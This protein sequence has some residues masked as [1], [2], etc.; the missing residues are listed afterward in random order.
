MCLPVEIHKLMPPDFVP[1]EQQTL[2]I[3]DRQAIKPADCVQQPRPRRYQRF[4]PA[5]KETSDD[6]DDDTTDASGTSDTSVPVQPFDPGLR[7]AQLPAGFNAAETAKVQRAERPLGMG[8]GL[9][10]KRAAP[11]GFRDVSEQRRSRI[12]S[13]AVPAGASLQ[14]AQSPPHTILSSATR[15][16]LFAAQSTS[17]AADALP[18]GLPSAPAHT[19]VPAI[20]PAASADRDAAAA[21][22]SVISAAAAHAR[23]LIDTAKQKE[24]STQGDLA[25]WRVAMA[26]VAAAGPL[27]AGQEQ[28]FNDGLHSRE[29]AYA[30]AQ[31][32]VAL[33]KQWSEYWSAALRGNTFL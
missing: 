2:T 29:Q 21:N 23:K 22:A 9:G 30:K 11:A 17:A 1:S 32:S 27:S 4:A 25:T 16:A 13:D 18:V 6:S 7:R 3:E 15:A 10:L 19:P 31:M 28:Y 24:T 20:P 12:G 14:Q 8:I 26:G 33:H 5:Y